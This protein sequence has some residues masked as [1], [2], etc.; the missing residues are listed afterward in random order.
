MQGGANWR[1]KVTVM[2]IH[3]SERT[4]ERTNEL[5]DRSKHVV[6]EGEESL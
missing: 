1:E 5:R 6:L 4:D 3:G 2:R